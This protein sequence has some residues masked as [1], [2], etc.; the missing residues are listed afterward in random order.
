MDNI[1][2]P[3]N[4]DNQTRDPRPRHTRW[5]ERLILLA[6]LLAG[7]VAMAKNHADADL[8]ATLRSA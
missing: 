8:G 7:S 6:L 3:G 2:A 5:L 1:I 4:D